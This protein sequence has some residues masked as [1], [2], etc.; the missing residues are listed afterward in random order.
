M[1]MLIVR[2]ENTGA[3]VRRLDMSVPPVHHREMKKGRHVYALVRERKVTRRFVQVP[4]V[5]V[6][7]TQAIVQVEILRRGPDPGQSYPQQA[8]VP[9]IEGSNDAL[10]QPEQSS[11]RL[12]DKDKLQSARFCGLMNREAAVIDSARLTALQMFTRLFNG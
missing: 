8:P 5:T 9:I 3:V 11:C 7:L 4:L 6:R 1:A 12:M 10:A 2:H